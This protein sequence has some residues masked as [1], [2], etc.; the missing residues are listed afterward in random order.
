MQP[1]Q[2]QEAQ[3]LSSKHSQPKSPEMFMYSTCSN[4]NRI[5]Q[6]K[7]FLAA[8]LP[9]VLV[10]FH[11]RLRF[12]F[13]CWDHLG[14]PCIPPQQHFLTYIVDTQLVEFRHK[15]TKNILYVISISFVGLCKVK[16]ERKNL[17][18]PSKCLAAS[19]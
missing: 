3:L 7:A 6:I 1:K 8:I 17:P 5:C 12:W 11:V 14:E 16:R 4:H 9:H 2:R 15:K 13:H 18:L 10:I 19:S